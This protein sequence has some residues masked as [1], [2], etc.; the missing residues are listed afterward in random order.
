[1][2]SIV[3]FMVETSFNGFLGSG[4]MPT[5][6]VERMAATSA[7]G[8]RPGERDE[9]GEVEPVA[10]RDQVIEAVARSDEGEADVAAP[11]SVHDDDPPPPGRGPHHPV[12]P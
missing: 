2:Y 8:I 10:L 4:E 7:S 1:M 9:V 5:S 3:L 12:A 11:E 6:A